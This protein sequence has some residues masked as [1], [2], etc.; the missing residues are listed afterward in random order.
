MEEGLRH[1]R[2]GKCTYCA[3]ELDMEK[4]VS[5]FQ[6]DYFH[7]KNIVCNGCGHK[8]WFRAHFFGSGHDYGFNTL[9]SIDSLVRKVCERER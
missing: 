7:Y 1:F 3:E 2:D 4:W 9:K 8:N 5:M 6:E